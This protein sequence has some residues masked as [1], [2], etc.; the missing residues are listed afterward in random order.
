[1]TRLVWS[2]AITA[3]GRRGFSG[4]DDKTV[5]IWDLETSACLGTLEGHVCIPCFRLRCLPTKHGSPQPVLLTER[6]GLWDWKSGTCLQVIERAE[7]PSS[8]AFSPDGSRLVVGTL[9]GPIY[10]YRLSGVLTATP[11]EPPRRYVNA[12]VVL[13]GESGVGKSGLAHR[14][15]EDQ[16]V[17]TESTHGMK[18]WRLDLPEGPQLDGANLER[19]ALLWDL[20]GQEDYRLIHQLFLDET[21][22]ALVLI[23]PQKD[24]PFAEVGDWLKAVRCGARDQRPT[25]RRSPDS[26]RGPHRRGRHPNRAAEDRSLPSTDHGFAGYLPVSAKTGDNCSDALEDGKPSAL[27]RLIAEQIPWER[28]PWTSTPRLLAAIKNAVV[29]MRD[30]KEIRLLRFA[31]LCQRLGADSDR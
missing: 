13:V 19:E 6:F 5:K 22:V 1:M 23:N 21:A 10:L 28:Q 12:K 17:P 25:T 29:E 7:S 2:V 30:K 24:D 14:L 9:A 18:V 20:A 4:S 11:L 3:D 8:V 15:I 16:F 26:H 27:K 31:E